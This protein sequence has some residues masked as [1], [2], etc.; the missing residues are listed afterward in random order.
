MAPG[1]YPA[2]REPHRLGREQYQELWR[3]VGFTMCAAEGRSLVSPRGAPAAIRDDL[4]AAAHD[5]GCAVIAYCIMP[6]HLHVL[7]CVVAP[8]GD[9]LDFM[10]HFKRRSGFELARLGQRGPVW[11][12]DFWDRHVRS[13][14]D[15]DQVVVYIMDNPVRAG[16]CERADDWRHSEFCGYPW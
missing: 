5:N 1:S 16:L 8:G 3:A 10:D 9:L 7:A 14:E 15:L 11:Q 2:R 4:R 6:N 12:R 13:D